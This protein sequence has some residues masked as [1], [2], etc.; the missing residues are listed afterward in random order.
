MK[1]PFTQSSYL[2]QVRRLRALAELV[3]AQYPIQV[4]SI[5]FINHGENTTFRI[6]SKDQQTYLLRIHR[7]D[8]HTKSAIHEEM[9][10]L[11]D[12]SKKGIKVPR[13]VFSKSKSLVETI[14]KPDVGLRHCTVFKWI[15]GSL[16]RGSVTPK[17]MYK[18]GTLL[19]DLQN[20]PPKMKSKHRQYWTAEG[21]IG[22][23]PK[24]GSIDN[25]KQLSKSQQNLVTTTRKSTFKKLKQYQ[26]Q[27]PNRLGLIHADLHFGNIISYKKILGAI[28]FD[29]C[30][31]GF[32][33][34][35]L[36]I[37]IISLQNS[38][39]KNKQYLIPK[40]KEAL[41]EGY[42][43]KRSWD[44]FDEEIFP[45]L[46]TARKLMMLGWLNSRSDNPKL[47]SYMKKAV[48]NVL[49]YL[50]KTKIS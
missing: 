4:K 47:K 28:D 9:S 44:Q 14:E 35:D 2:S 42:K 13:P 21:L 27:F 1:K 5:R 40:Y 49:I 7:S 31:F 26:N 20:N 6:D 32:F 18:L 11:T 38:F 25:L 30:G 23:N 50:K 36:V 10:W 41:I 17:Q 39:K 37:P 15:H 33:V 29:D 46:M 22:P 34:Y 19:A 16:I 8:Y 3:L 45:H 43:S 48:K 12:L 24:F